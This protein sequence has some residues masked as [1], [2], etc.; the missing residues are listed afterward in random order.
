MADRF[1]LID[2]GVLQTLWEVGGVEALENLFDRGPDQRG[3][4]NVQS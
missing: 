3:W 4:C 2:N 1:L